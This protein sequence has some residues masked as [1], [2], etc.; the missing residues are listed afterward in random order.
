MI[1]AL[2]IMFSILL[3]W[4]CYMV[5]S[6]SLNSNLFK[7]WDFLTWS[8][9][10]GKAAAARYQSC[11]P[12]RTGRNIRRGGVLWRN[13]TPAV[14]YASCGISNCCCASLRR[15]CIVAIFA[16]SSLTLVREGLGAPQAPQAKPPIPG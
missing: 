11:S 5:I 9:L 10:T 4:M 14:R 8:R 6:T 2:K 13:S 12:L 7:E 3:V 1:T 16:D 15:V